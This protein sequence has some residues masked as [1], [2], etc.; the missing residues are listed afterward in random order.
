MTSLGD[1]SAFFDADRLLAQHQAAL[2][3]IQDMLS[4]P[5]C[6]HLPWLDL[7]CGKGQIIAHLDKNLSTS[8]RKKIR[9][10]GYDI[11]NA[12]SKH[13][14]RIAE[15]MELDSYVFEVGSLGKFW[16]NGTTSGPWRFITLTNTTHEIE[17]SSLAAILT[18]CIERL[19]E[20]GCLFLYDME[21][22]PTPELGAVPWSAAEMKAILATLCHSLGAD[23]SFEPAVGT[24]AHR[25]CNGWNALIRRTHL[26]LPENFTNRLDAAIE[27]TSERI[28]DL[29]RERALRVRAALESLTEHGPE[30]GEEANEKEFLLYEFWAVSRALGGTQ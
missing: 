25:T 6:E 16:E 21:R 3:L 30:T 10:V 20:D 18:R 7:A 14:K 2:T 26:G 27:N 11:E 19:A 15:S 8:S 17:P 23:P 24:W 5:A 29:L 12:H 4:D 1:S 22:L 9:L 13:A 28:R